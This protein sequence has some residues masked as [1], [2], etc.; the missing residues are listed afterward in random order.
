M[1]G[2]APERWTLPDLSALI[3]PP[4]DTIIDARSPAEFAQD[5]LPGAINLPVLDDGERA[6]VGTIYKQD[7]PFRARRIGAALVSRNI[8]RHL[9]GPL[10]DRPGRWHP[11][12]YCWRGGQR[13]GALA[14]VLAQV[15]WRVAVLDG[16]YRSFRRAVVAM[17]YER[18]LPVPVIVLAGGTGTAKT[19]V[20]RAVAAAGGAAIDLEGLANHRG[21][22]FGARPGGQPAQKGFESAIAMALAG[23]PAA[24]PL[25]V[26]DESA[27]IGTLRLPPSLWAAMRTA[28]RIALRAGAASRARYLA[29]DYADIA[30]DRAGFS[31]ML[32][33]LVPLHGRARVADW[34]GL[35][36]QGATEALAA[37][38]IARHYDP[39]YGRLRGPTP[40]AEVTVPDEA[41]DAGAFETVAQAVLAEMKRLRGGTA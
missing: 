35:A 41:L 11:L 29:R 32:D 37:D 20:L 26:E 18:P 14:A 38:L 27:R 12:I 24:A 3:D 31:A 36:A 25:L 7:S 23:P 21:S 4:F 9:D 34:Q 10:A 19:A 16:G 6:R 30:A 2:P 28:P 5:R 22:A 40:A 39:A 33:R 17:L 15:G 1:A 8:A 13:S